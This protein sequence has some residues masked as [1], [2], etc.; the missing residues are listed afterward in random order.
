MIQK[1]IDLFLPAFT[2]VSLV[3]ELNELA[4]CN[5][6][7]NI[8]VWCVDAQNTASLPP[9]TTLLPIKEFGDSDMYVDMA[10]RADADYTI[11][12]LKELNPL[13]TV[14]ALLRMCDSMHEDSSMLYS[15]YSKMINGM[16]EEAP[17]IDYQSGSLRNDFDFGSVVVLRT[18]L[19][20]KYI[21]QKLAY[22]K[23]A[24][25]YQLRLAMSRLGTLQHLAECLYAEHERDTRK[26]GEKQFDYV[27]PSQRDVQIEMERVCTDHLKRTGGY[28]IP[29]K[30]TEIDLSIGDFPVEA[31]VVIPVLNRASTIADAIKSVL[32][33]KC[34]F[35]FNILV[36]DNHS[37]DETG[38][39]IDSFCD[40]RVHHIIPDSHDLGIGGCWNL[41][42][43]SEHCGRFAVQLDSDDLYSDENTLQRVVDGFYEQKCAML[44]GSY[45]ICNFELETLP[46]GVIDHREWSEE[47]GRNNALRING[48]GAPRAFFTP[49]IREVGFPNVSY[50]E[51]YAVGLQ[52]SR[53]YRVGRIYDVLYLCRR[54]GGNS[55]AALSQSKVNAHNYYKDSL[56][57]VELNARIELMATVKQLPY[58]SLIRFFDRQLSS[59]DMVA[60]QF[61]DLDNVSVRKL[62]CG[63]TLQYN[64]ARIVSAS[65]NVDMKYVAKR[66]CFLCE[67]NRSKEQMTEKVLG[68]M[69]VLVNP[70]PILK[71][72]FTLPLERH[73]PQQLMPMFV[74]M[75]LLAK[76]WKKMAIFYNGPKC[77]A[78]APDHAHLQAVFASD[79][80]LLGRVWR[81]RLWQ[82]AYPVYANTGNFIYRI[83]SYV[84]PLY[85]IEAVDIGNALSL[86]K[87]LMHALPLC[88]GEDEP[89][90]NVVTTYCAPKGYSIYVFPRAKHRPDCYY[91]IGRNGRM[92]SP[93][94][95]DMAGIVVTPQKEDFENL[96]DSEVV[97]ILK[98]VAIDENV[99]LDVEQKLNE[100]L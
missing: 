43:N 46:P 95:L 18:S 6:I 13:P 63:V 44:I 14:D 56:R 62:N 97:S 41:A 12:L 33:Q 61:S 57:T 74:N 65:A 60:K 4:A 29:Y 45:R 71:T 3:D 26:S 89:K 79:V 5:R 98:E 31:S 15:D 82:G 2:N 25:F 32:S 35:P 86:M 38:K 70:F 9:K 48:L 51:D 22:T 84:V 8:Y 7:N 53:T 24:G 99:A 36:V 52:I 94:F 69:E 16:C 50:G 90:M 54:W 93:G 55:D 78:S 40:K 39:I 30:Y 42:V 80:P 66:P 21:S 19:L 87:R 77:G 85:I 64:P 11:T 20:K 37:T 23:Y 81:I 75:L 59:W 96:T 83:T 91:S 73:L 88:D 72:H 49:V 28:L 10:R 100:G 1:T 27:N 34:T 58:V 17:T 68:D 47:N 92:V 76:R 67:K